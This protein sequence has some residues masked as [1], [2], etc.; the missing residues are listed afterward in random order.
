EPFVVLSPAYAI[1]RGLILVLLASLLIWVPPRSLQMRLGLAAGSAAAFTTA[2]WLVATYAVNF[3]DIMLFVLVS[4][5]FA[6]EALELQIANQPA[7]KT[8]A[9]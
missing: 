5:I 4:I 1:G 2:V 7:E 8:T 6:I 3:L 9:S